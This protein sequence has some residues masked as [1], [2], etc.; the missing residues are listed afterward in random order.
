MTTFVLLGSI[1]SDLGR[2][3]AE[4]GAEFGI[5]WR[6]FVAQVINFCVV[7]FLLHR[8]AFKPILR[9]LEERRNTIA[10]SLANAEKIKAELAQAQEKA[11]EIVATATERA[12]RIVEEA[13]RTA[14]DYRARETARALHEAEMIVARAREAAAL[15]R[16]R[17]L[18]ELR[19][20]LGSL[21]VDATG[22]VVGRALTAE[23]RQRLL[24]EALRELRA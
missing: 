8:F 19:G 14:A 7:A 24:E 1:V 23:D 12:N 6:V 5:D 18:E 16:T 22:R 15:E 17:M 13:R 9:V 21:V 10:E 2:T 11:Q 20:E 4:I 3:A